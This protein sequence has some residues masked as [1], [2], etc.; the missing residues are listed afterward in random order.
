MI[1]D[2]Q[3]PYT[4]YG[5]QQ[6]SGTVAIASRT[7]HGIITEKDWGSAGGS[8]SGYMAPD[9]ADPD[10]V[11]VAGVYGTLTRYDKRTAQ[12]QNVT[13]WPLF[14][15]N[16]DLEKVKYRYPWTP[17]LIFSPTE[18]GTLYFGSQHLM[19]TANGGLDWQEIS[20]DLTGPGKLG[21]VYSIAPS[22]VT[23]AQ[24]WMGT[25]TGLLHMTRN[26][27]KTWANVTP[28]GLSQ[29]SKVTHIEA[30]HFDAATAYAAVDR[31]RLDDYKPY[32]YRT[33]DYGKTWTLV[34]EGLAEPAFVNAVREDP[35]R[36]GMLY[37]A[38]ELGV[39]LFTAT[40][41]S[42]AAEQ[43]KKAL[44]I[45][46]TYTDARFNL[47]SVEASSGQ[48]EA[49]AADYKR[50]LTERPDYAKA[51][52]HLG[53]VLL[54]WGDSLAKSG[55]DEQA[56]THY[57]EALPYRT[58][59]PQLH[60][61]LAMAFARMERLDESQAEFEAVLRLNPGDQIAKQAIEA[62]QARKKSTGK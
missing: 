29:W 14:Q 21:V 36:R 2:N 52:E 55:Q 30:S 20:P 19:K 8:E 54:L 13:P 18:R 32:V 7:N 44:A 4:V 12:G 6:D 62:I 27:G 34:T 60:G 37:A 31:H 61:R 35:V 59:D 43:L 10:I 3:F 1:T 50:V 28:P 48:W 9:P 51:E 16:V 26:G 24:I 58:S 46:P 56:V 22:P 11:Y 25:D 33:R 15:F 39:A 57:R 38:T 23:P 49:A 41:T 40:K 17:A 5:T 45:D 42:E 53:E 47:A